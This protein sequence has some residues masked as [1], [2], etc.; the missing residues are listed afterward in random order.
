MSA[1][2]IDDPV[3]I[4]KACDMKKAGM[5]V[6]DISTELSNEYGQKVTQVALWRLFNSKKVPHNQITDYVYPSMEDIAFLF[7][8]KV[9]QLT[10][11]TNIQHHN[12]AIRRSVMVEILNKFYKGSFTFEEVE[13]EMFKSSDRESTVCHLDYL[14][15]YHY[16]EEIYDG[17]YKFCEPVKQWKINN[18]VTIKHIL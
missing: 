2:Y 4:Q 1:T 12:K 7:S 6:R 15:K 18:I 17:K 11:K 13:K 3:I 14:K 10:S 16:I 8:K 9:N 5:Y